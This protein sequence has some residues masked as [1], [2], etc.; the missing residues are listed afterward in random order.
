MDKSKKKYE[1]KICFFKSNKKCNYISHLKTQKHLRNLNIKNENNK[2]NNFLC[3]CGKIYKY[4]SGLWRHRKKCVITD[5]LEEMKNEIIELKNENQIMKNNTTEILEVIKQSS[6]NNTDLINEVKKLK[7]KNNQQITQNI[8][9]Q[10]N[11]T[12][13]ISINV[14]LNEHCQN[15]M[16]L[17]DFVKKLHV[18]IEDISHTGKTNYVEGIS[19]ILINNLNKMDKLERP[20]HCSDVKRK[21][22]YIKNG[23]GWEKDQEHAKIK[24]CIKDVEFKQIKKIPEWVKEKNIDIYKCDAQGMKYQNVVFNSMGGMNNCKREKN[25]SCVIKKLSETTDYKE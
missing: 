5:K 7:Q 4:H 16:S 1:C 23:E 17:T 3:D 24:K 2:V 11:N 8:Q 9:N 25:K 13:N 19:R 10:T 12:Q 6:V 22:L 15:A 14:F 18:T 21:V 20:I